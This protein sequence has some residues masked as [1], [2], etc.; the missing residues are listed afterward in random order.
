MNSQEVVFLQGAHQCN[1][2]T[3]RAFIPALISSVYHSDV[4]RNLTPGEAVRA[5]Y[6][7]NTAFTGRAT[8]K[9]RLRRGRQ[10][11]RK[12]EVCG[13]TNWRLGKAGEQRQKALL[14]SC[15][16]T[17]TPSQDDACRMPS[18]VTVRQRSSHQ[19]IPVS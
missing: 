11:N 13:N 19:S 4:L 14:H 5:G 16:M 18:L 10:G 1:Y 9:R 7:P 15:F 12:A 8:N 6:S 17:S 3:L 2:L